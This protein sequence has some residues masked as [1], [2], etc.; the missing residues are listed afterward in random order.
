M[1]QQ[2][3]AHRSIRGHPLPWCPFDA[4]FP[5]YPSLP[6]HPSATF[7]R[8]RV[9]NMS[10]LSCN[11]LLEL[12]G[13]KWMIVFKTIRLQWK[14]VYVKFNEY[15]IYIL[16]FIKFYFINYLEFLLFEL[17]P[18]FNLFIRNVSFYMNEVKINLWSINIR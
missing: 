7:D 15:T 13:K 1:R 2:Q 17:L 4:T 18:S 3:A 10:R 9:N 12:L 6:R 8:L 14:F 16:Y 5:C 11:P